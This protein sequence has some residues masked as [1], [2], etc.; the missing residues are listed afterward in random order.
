MSV[1]RYQNYL[2]VLFEDNAYKDLFM[3]FDFSMQKQIS[4]RPVCDGFDSVCIQLTSEK[5]VL[6]KELNQFSK[7][8]VL[9]LIDA[10]LDN[11][12]YS[13]RGKIDKLRTSIDNKYQDRI[14]IIGSKIEAEDIKRAI[15]SQ[16]EWKAVSQKLENSC[17]NENCEL[18]QDDM[19]K[20]NLDEIT[21]LKQVFNWE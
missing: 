7:A 16:G 18:W 11:H 21:R 15:I 10:D 6:L 13:Q 4:L 1:N 14:F 9:A 8:Y 2:I 3:G 5:G 19:L 20:H 17:K 12:P